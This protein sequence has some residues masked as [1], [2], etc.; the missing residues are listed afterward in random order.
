[1]KADM[2]IPFPNRKMKGLF[3]HKTRFEGQAL[4]TRAAALPSRMLAGVLCAAMALAGCVETSKATVGRKVSEAESYMKSPKGAIPPHELELV[5]LGMTPIEVDEILQPFFEINR[6]Y[7]SDE[8]GAIRDSFTYSDGIEF[9]R[10][11]IYYTEERVD[12]IRFGYSIQE[13]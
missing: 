9:K 11:Y 2:E 12:E 6:Y 5:K 13:E 8:V 3:M 4:S 10:A 1:M 7:S